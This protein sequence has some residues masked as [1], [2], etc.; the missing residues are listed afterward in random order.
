IGVIDARQQEG[1]DSFRR[2]SVLYGPAGNLRHRPP[3]HRSSIRVYVERSLLPCLYGSDVQLSKLPLADGGRGALEEGTGGRGLGKRDHVPQTGRP[4]E[5][6]REPIEAE[7][8]T[9]VRRRPEAE[10][11]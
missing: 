1:V 9:R 10:R 8:E 5:K 3:G 6:H 7:R 11:L 2:D 4:G